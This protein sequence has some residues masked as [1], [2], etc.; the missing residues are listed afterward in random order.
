MAE[1]YGV[2]YVLQCLYLIDL[3]LLCR[4]CLLGGSPFERVS[5][6]LAACR[7]L[8]DS[9]GVSLDHTFP[10]GASWLSPAVSV[11]GEPAE[12]GD[13]G[14]MPLTVDH[15]PYDEANYQQ[16]TQQGAHYDDDHVIR[17]FFRD[18]GKLIA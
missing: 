15:G 10:L 16:D 11:I 14:A 2:S 3:F 4:H 5:T 7:D 9:K 18:C 6:S 13:G 12:L 8:E 17:A 1:V